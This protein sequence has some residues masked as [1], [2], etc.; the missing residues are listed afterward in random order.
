ML[1]Q[2][3]TCGTCKPKSPSEIQHTFH[4]SSNFSFARWWV[5]AGF[6][7]WSEK[8]SGIAL[9]RGQSSDEKTQRQKRA[10]TMKSQTKRESRSTFRTEG[11]KLSVGRLFWLFSFILYQP[12]FVSFRYYY[13]RIS[14]RWPKSHYQPSS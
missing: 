12:V 10:T 9:S 11:G 7:R 6:G 5:F 13:F 2:C 14:L 3:S 4:H 8:S 1:F